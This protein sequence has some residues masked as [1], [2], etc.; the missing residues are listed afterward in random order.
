MSGITTTGADQ[1]NAEELRASIVRRLDEFDHTTAPLDGARGAAVVIAVTS[2]NGEYGI[3]L[4]KRP[5]KMREHPGQFALPGGRI[6]PGE[7]YATAALRELHE[8]LGVEVDRADVLGRLDDYVTRSGYVITPIVCWAGP[9]RETTPN[10]GEVAQLFF[11]PMA[12]LQVTPRFIDIPESDR[13]VIQMPLVG[14]LIHAPTGAVM[15]QFAEVV[16][17]GRA[18]RVND[19]E[20]PVFAWR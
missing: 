17:G 13:P 18:T 7:D 9:D 4:T 12:D 3:W 11:I 19:F 5:S 8:E 6:E 1:D 16:L 15:Y 14:S 20:Q 10:P 2:R